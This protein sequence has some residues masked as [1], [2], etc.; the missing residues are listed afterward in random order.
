MSTAG[1]FVLPRYGCQK[2][3]GKVFC[4]VSV[5]R[6]LGTVPDEVFL[7]TPGEALLMIWGVFI[8]I[9]MAEQGVVSDG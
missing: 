8:Y 9:V 5:E 3:F 1:F 4:R 6:I 2:G 7:I